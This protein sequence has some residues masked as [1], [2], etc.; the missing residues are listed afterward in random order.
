MKPKFANSSPL[1]YITIAGGV[2]RPDLLFISKEDA[3]KFAASEISSYSI[4]H[5]NPAKI[6]VGLEDDETDRLMAEKKALEAKLAEV[7][8]KLKD[9]TQ[10][11][12]GKFSDF[13]N[14]FL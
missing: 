14:L 8:K 11:T 7:N 3:E 5:I 9:N 1:Y 2:Y 13:M 4:A 10:Q 6:V 12:T